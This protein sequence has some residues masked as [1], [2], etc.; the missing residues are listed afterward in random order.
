M[1]FCL[2]GY[3]Y[4]VVFICAL[5]VILLLLLILFVFICHHRRTANSHMHACSKYN[6]DYEIERSN[7][8]QN[9]E[10][11]R[12]Y[13]NPLKNSPVEDEGGGYRVQRVAKGRSWTPEGAGRYSLKASMS[14]STKMCSLASVSTE[15]L[16]LDLKRSGGDIPSHI[17]KA[18]SPEVQKNTTPVEDQ[19]WPHK[20]FEKD[21]NLRTLPSIKRTTHI[22]HI[23][24]DSSDTPSS[25]IV[26]STEVIV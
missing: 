21:V 14:A 1:S 23:S 13:H 18:R 10:N 19:A 9:E 25:D 24:S 2:A 15:M 16:D 3:L 8:I 11:L 6:E 5:P 7:N 20:Q 17:F 26:T 22:V 4:Q 12:R